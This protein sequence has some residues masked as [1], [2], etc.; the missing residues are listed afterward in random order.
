MTVATAKIALDPS[1]GIIAENI[2]GQL[3]TFCTVAANQIVVGGE[4]ETISD[5]VLGG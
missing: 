4:G 3:G 2:T 1:K 5:E